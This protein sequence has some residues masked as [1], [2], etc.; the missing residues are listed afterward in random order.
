MLTFEGQNIQGSQNFV[1]KL[2]GLKSSARLLQVNKLTGK[3]PK[4]IGLM[5]TL[6]VCFKSNGGSGTPPDAAAAFTTVHSDFDGDDL[7]LIMSIFLAASFCCCESILAGLFRGLTLLEVR[8]LGE[9]K[10]IVNDDDAI[11]VLDGS[12]ESKVDDAFFNQVVALPS[13]GLF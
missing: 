6:A 9:G 3:I 1:A 10:A 13:A 2:T 11:M 7:Q 8:P 5:Q 4:V 12:A